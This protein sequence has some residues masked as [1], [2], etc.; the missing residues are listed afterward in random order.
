M[1]HRRN[2]GCGCQQSPIIHPTKHNCVHH[3][4]ESVVEHIHPS[5]TTVM[6]HHVV[7][8]KHVF[9]HSTSV[10]NTCSNVDEF[11]GS[12]NTPP[13]MSPGFGPGNGNN[14]SNQVAGAMDQ[15][16]GHGNNHH[17]N[18]W[19]N[20]NHCNNNHGPKHWNKPNKWC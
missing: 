7:K 3:C 2:C 12:F 15:G 14:N 1:R 20:H 5:H 4:T 13:Q 18:N 9:P 17:H 19:N 6:N 11:G 16:M 10:K 8:N